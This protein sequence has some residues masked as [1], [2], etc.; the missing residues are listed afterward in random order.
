M[1]VFG[2]MDNAGLFFGATYLDEVFEMFPGAED[3][4][5]F[6][7]YGNT[8]SDFLGA[9]LGTFCGFIIADMT[10]KDPEVCPLWIH[11][12]A[13]VIGCLIGIVIPKWIVGD[14]SD[15]HGINKINAKQALL[16][17][18]DEDEVY[19]II[20]NKKKAF[21]FRAEKIFRHIDTDESKT[22]EK[23]EIK[24]QLERALGESYH[25]DEFDKVIK[26]FFSHK[27]DSFTMDEFKMVQ[28]EMAKK[29]MDEES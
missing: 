25:D 1:L 16:G 24:A 21:D 12:I 2:F 14:D 13:L 6:A 27:E 7:G 26:Q 11:A 18:L 5:V 19:E 20:L 4:N 8:Y 23:T 10:D 15:Q 3:A 9:F 22:L 28:R 29:M 17:N